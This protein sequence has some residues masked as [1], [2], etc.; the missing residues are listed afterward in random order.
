MYMYII[1]L[2]KYV[3][4]HFKEH[5]KLIQVSLSLEKKFELGLKF[6]KHLK[7]ESFGAQILG[8]V[9]FLFWVKKASNFTAYD[10]I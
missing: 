6:F 5:I 1:L 8:P 10:H 2:F 9:L 7:N 4:S 3:I